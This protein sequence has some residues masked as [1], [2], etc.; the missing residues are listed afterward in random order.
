[1]RTG[2]QV[3]LVNQAAQVGMD[4]D[5]S[6]ATNTAIA[7]FREMVKFTARAE[8]LEEELSVLTGRIPEEELHAYIKATTEIENSV[9]DATRRALG[10]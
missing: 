1:M 5:L 3:A 2:A 6:S 8:L 7:K 10:R 4:L 9:Y